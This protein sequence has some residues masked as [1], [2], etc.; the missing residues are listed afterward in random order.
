[1]RRTKLLEWT[2][3][4]RKYLGSGS[5]VHKG[6]VLGFVVGRMKAVSDADELAFKT[7]LRDVAKSNIVETP[8]RSTLSAVAGE[9]A[10]VA[11]ERPNKLMRSQSSSASLAMAGRLAVR[12]PL[13][14]SPRIGRYSAEVYEMQGSSSEWGWLYM[15]WASQGGKIGTQMAGMSYSILLLRSSSERSCSISCLR[16]NADF[17]P[18]P[19]RDS[20][21]RNSAALVGFKAIRG[22]CL[23][24]ND[25]LIEVSAAAG[26]LRSKAVPVFGSAPGC[27]FLFG[28]KTAWNFCDV[29]YAAL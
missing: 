18:S 20:T 3:V 15:P 24:A 10:I 1:M 19:P 21:H 6:L 11:K 9:T 12:Y 26:F 14:V 4:S 7:V 8:R 5:A 17:L 2:K 23:Y 13:P 25:K 27:V 28:D 22:W 29:F 16:V